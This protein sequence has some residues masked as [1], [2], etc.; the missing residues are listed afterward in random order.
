M[1]ILWCNTI[2][3]FS[4][5][6][7]LTSTPNLV[8]SHEGRYDIRFMHA[9]VPLN[10]TSWWMKCFVSL[11][12]CKDSTTHWQSLIFLKQPRGK[13]SP[14]D[15]LVHFDSALLLSYQQAQ[16]PSHYQPTLLTDTDCIEKNQVCY[17]GVGWEATHCIIHWIYCQGLKVCLTPNF[18]RNVIPNKPLSLWVGS[19]KDE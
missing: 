17:L 3:I 15:L 19:L 11:V 14:A 12:L 10:A 5:Q 4:Q 8:D 6:R 7:W 13:N 16:S 18:K 2:Y 9:L 1:A